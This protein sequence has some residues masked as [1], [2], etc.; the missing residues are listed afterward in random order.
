[1]RVLGIGHCTLDHIGGVDRFA[2]PDFKKELM[3]FSTQG[4]G[5]T[6]TALVALSRWGVETAFIGKTGDDSRG[7]EIVRTMAEEGVDT[8]H[9]I[10]QPGAVSQLSFIIAE[11]SGRKQSYTTEGNVADLDPGEF[12]IDEV[13]EGIDILL[14]DGTHVPAELQL[15]RAARERGIKVVLDASVLRDGIGEAVAACDFL[16]ASERF[17]S[18]FAGIGQLESLCEALLQKGPSTVCVTLGNEGA[19]AMVEGQAMHRRDSFPVDV[20]D[21]TGAGDVFH[22]AVIYGISQDW[23][24]PRW[25]DFASVA[26]GLSC[27]GIG[28]RSAIPS[29]EDVLAEI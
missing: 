6:A 18:Q 16:V 7:S 28:G 22:G 5:S 13:L 19:V 15:M 14:A 23:Q 29:I 21:T 24:L 12:D 25:L 4:G 2:E 26:A 10:Q 1:M 8:S 3:Q 11:A 9:M 17:A 27:R 20:V